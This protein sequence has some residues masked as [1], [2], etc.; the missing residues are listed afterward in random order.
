MRDGGGTGEEKQHGK[1]GETVERKKINGNKGV[2]SSKKLDGGKK[3]G[4]ERYTG[5]IIK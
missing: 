3:E 1:K 2:K 4:R 5:K